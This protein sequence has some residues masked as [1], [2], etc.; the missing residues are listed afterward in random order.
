MESRD[1]AID[2][3]DI[4]LVAIEPGKAVAAMTVTDDM[5]N[6]HGVCHGGFIFLLADTTMDYASNSGGDGTA[7]AAHAEVD[8][9]RPSVVG[10]RLVAT[11]VVHDGWGRSQLIDATVVNSATGATVAHFRGRTRTTYG[12]TAE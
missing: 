6:S 1:P 11:G 2:S 10:D 5:L 9:L 3:L 4:E 7:F 8:Y 12:R